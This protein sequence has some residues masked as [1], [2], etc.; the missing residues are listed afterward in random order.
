AQRFK[1]KGYK[2]T[3]WVYSGHKNYNYIFMFKT[4]T[5]AEALEKL[6]VA[7]DAGVKDAWIQ[8]LIVK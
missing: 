7:K 1:D 2:T 8:E 4:N 3:D 5:K 6:K